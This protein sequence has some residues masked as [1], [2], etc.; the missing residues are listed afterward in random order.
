MILIP[1]SKTTE[2]VQDFRCKDSSTRTIRRDTDNAPSQ[3]QFSKEERNPTTVRNTDT[4]PGRTKMTA[5]QEQAQEVVPNS[6][7]QQP[8]NRRGGKKHLEANP[9]RKNQ[10]ATSTTSSRATTGSNRRFSRRKSST[11]STRRRHTQPTP[12]DNWNSQLEFGYSN[13]IPP[14]MYYYY[15]DTPTAAYL[16]PPFYDY[17]GTTAPSS[18]NEDTAS[19][20]D[21]TAATTMTIQPLQPYL[22]TA[23]CGMAEQPSYYYQ[24]HQY[25]PV[26]EMTSNT[27]TNSYYNNNND[28]CSMV[29]YPPPV[30][31]AT[32]A[33]YE[34]TALLPP[35]ATAT[36]NITTHSPDCSTTS[37]P[38]YSYDYDG[39]T[40]YYSPRDVQL[41]MPS[42]TIDTTA[43]QIDFTTHFN[44][45]GVSSPTTKTCGISTASVNNNN[46]TSVHREEVEIP[47]RYV[48]AST[49]IGTA[50]DHPNVKSSTTIS[51][52]K[53][54]PSSCP[55]T[56]V[57]I[58]R[59]EYYPCYSFDYHQLYH[60]YWQP[61]AVS[62]DSISFSG[63]G[64]PFQSHQQEHYPAIVDLIEGN[65][66]AP[67]KEH[68]AAAAFS[69]IGA[70][71]FPTSSTGSTVLRKEDDAVKEENSTTK[72]EFSKKEEVN[73]SVPQVSR[74]TLLEDE[75]LTPLLQAFHLESSK[76]I[77]SSV[78]HAVITYAKN[79]SSDSYG[80]D[81]LLTKLDQK[82]HAISLSNRRT[83]DETANAVSSNN[84]L[85]GT[86]QQHQQQ[87]KRLLLLALESK[88]EF[89]V[90]NDL[91]LK[92]TNENT[93]YNAR[94]AALAELPVQDHPKNVPKSH[95]PMKNSL[96]VKKKAK[97]KQKQP[98][99]HF[100]ELV[101]E[102]LICII[103]NHLQPI[104]KH[105]LSDP[106]KISE[107]HCSKKKLQ[108]YEECQRLLLIAQLLQKK[109]IQMN[110]PTKLMFEKYSRQFS[111]NAALHYAIEDGKSWD[112]IK[113][114]I[115]DRFPASIIEQK[116]D[117]L[118]PC[119][120]A[121][122]C[123]ASSL[124]IVYQLLVSNTCW[125]P[126]QTE[127]RT[128]G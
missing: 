12:Q 56:T 2:E 14:S 32:A 19:L 64:N 100:L 127:T 11:R 34:S 85:T 90:I 3:R 95:V 59:E 29:N 82:N 30:A 43:A 5:T 96:K 69:P 66:R 60:Q 63:P 27:S 58:P 15:Q 77:P 84:S 8:R 7:W 117:N 102:K 24:Y 16:S 123:E 124:D 106:S 105:Q 79:K 111:K 121:A 38:Y 48:P 36:T 50:Q 71:A 94:R 73:E 47:V 108:G 110:H 98:R 128:G 107:T 4:T 33:S 62:N 44:A 70:E 89:D 67:S 20:L 52:S 23:S 119:F 91:V 78:L 10:L 115:L 126:S 28:Y 26:P 37:S 75:L 86:K 109:G 93:A 53:I 81:D 80:F 116:K 42:S 65:A 99:H 61:A 35:N 25:P 72:A 17:S 46:I 101:L 1:R 22:L 31:W 92:C 83:D 39:T 57:A 13:T 18:Y 125:V 76:D 118:Y 9:T 6:Q 88:C 87:Q 113:T 74:P 54:E 104:H 41:C 21:P 51:D 49:T 97:S 112:W 103:T 40:F 45:E 120:V 122:T 68:G 114:M 55:I